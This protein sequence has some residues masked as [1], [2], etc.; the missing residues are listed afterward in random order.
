MGVEVFF[1]NLICCLLVVGH[2]NTEVRRKQQERQR[3]SALRHSASELPDWLK[4]LVFQN[5]FGA[6][7]LFLRIYVR[8]GLRFGRSIRS[9]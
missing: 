3:Q 1:T 5:A 2:L 4:V 6:F 8:N 7:S 9:D